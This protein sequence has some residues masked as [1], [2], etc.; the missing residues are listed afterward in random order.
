MRAFAR[1]ATNNEPM[2]ELAFREQNTM[3]SLS[4]VGLLDHECGTGRVCLPSNCARLA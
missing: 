2:L 4:S 3:L 1:V